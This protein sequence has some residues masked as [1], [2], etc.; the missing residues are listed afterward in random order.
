MSTESYIKYYVKVANTDIAFARF[1]LDTLTV[2]EFIY[3]LQCVGANVLDVEYDMV[4]VVEAGQEID[5]LK[6]EDAPKLESE[7]ITMVQKYG[8]RIKKC[9]VAFYLRKAQ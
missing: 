2:D 9:Y 8:S 6:P 7:N 5:D 1:Y 4:E 3:E